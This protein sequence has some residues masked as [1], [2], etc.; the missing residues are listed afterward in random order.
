MH[1]AAGFLRLNDRPGLILG[2][3]R[4]RIIVA[5]VLHLIRGWYGHCC[6]W[7]FAYRWCA[8]QECLAIQFICQVALHKL[9]SGF[10]YWIHFGGRRLSEIEALRYLALLIYTTTRAY[11]CPL[12]DKLWGARP[13]LI[14]KIQINIELFDDLFSPLLCINNHYDTVF[15]ALVN[16]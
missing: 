2:C 6:G 13:H 7:L 14:F 9:R 4:S 8:S 16:I 1:I 3:C 12:G 10:W 11:W 5:Q 15:R